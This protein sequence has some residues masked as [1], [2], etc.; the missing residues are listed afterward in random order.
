MKVESRA[1]IAIYRIRQAAEGWDSSRGEPASRVTLVAS[2][3]LG[4]PSRTRELTSRRA[5]PPRLGAGPEGGLM[6]LANPAILGAAG[7]GEELASHSGGN[8]GRGKC[9]RSLYLPRFQEGCQRLSLKTVRLEAAA[10]VVSTLSRERR[11]WNPGILESWMERGPSG[12]HGG[13]LGQLAGPSGLQGG[14]I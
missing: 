2:P 10:L 3:S 9:W 11:A 13:Q 1:A 7:S 8:E 5:S 12:H 14:W 6:H 4:Q